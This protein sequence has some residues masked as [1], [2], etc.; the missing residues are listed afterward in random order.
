LPLDAPEEENAETGEMVKRD[1]LKAALSGA[2]KGALIGGGVGAVGGG[3]QGVHIGD[4]V[5]NL[6]KGNNYN[7]FKK[8]TKRDIAEFLINYPQAALK[9]LKTLIGKR[10]L[11]KREDLIE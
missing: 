6:E 1:R 8:I 9:H 7:L 5:K 2:G 10:R 3:L 4:M 11:P